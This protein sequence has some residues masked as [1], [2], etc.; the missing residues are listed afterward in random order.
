MVIGARSQRWASVSPGD[1]FGGQIAG[2]VD[3]AR[4]V[5]TDDSRMLK[6]G[7]VARFLE[8]QP[9]ILRRGPIARARQ[10]QCNEAAE[11]CVKGFIN[12]SN[13]AAA[14]P[15]ENLEFA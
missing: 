3:L 15:L 11:L 7:G 6:T 14:K 8:Q 2:A 5:D 4:L 9:Y 12:S 10:F 13:G 1:V